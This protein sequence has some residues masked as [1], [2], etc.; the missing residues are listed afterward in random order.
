[1]MDSLTMGST[2]T[3]EG[4]FSIIYYLFILMKWGKEDYEPWLK[5]HVLAWC[6]HAAAGTIPMDARLTSLQL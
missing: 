3:I 2:K 4:T 6:R 1:M 5:K